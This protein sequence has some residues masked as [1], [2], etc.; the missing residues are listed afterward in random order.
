MPDACLLA[1]CL[2][3]RVWTGARALSVGLVDALGGVHRAV[4]V[5]KQ[6][7]SIPADEPVAIMELGRVRT[8]PLAL[9]GERHAIWV[10]AWLNRRTLPVTTG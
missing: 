2:Q 10:Y 4:A 5:A 3:G 8:S 6:L 1:S 7:A 9:L